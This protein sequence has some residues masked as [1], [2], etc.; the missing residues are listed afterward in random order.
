MFLVF[1]EYRGFVVI[2]CSCFLVFVCTCDLFF[3]VSCVHLCFVFQRFVCLGVSCFSYAVFL[4]ALRLLLRRVSLRFVFLDV[5]CS[6]VNRVVCFVFFGFPSLLLLRA[7]WCFVFP[8]SLWCLGGP[9]TY[10]GDLVGPWVEGEAWSELLAL[11]GFGG[12]VL[13]R[14]RATSIHF[15]RIRNDIP[16]KD[17]K[18]YSSEQL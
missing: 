12:T 18:H 4:C 8:G 16:S 7:S 15:L 10:L 3:S 14:P 2:G 13:E 6:L 5:S 11:G 9:L 1:R 17:P